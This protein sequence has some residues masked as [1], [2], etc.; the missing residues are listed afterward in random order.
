MD[1]PLPDEDN[2]RGR[3][4]S[5][6][7]RRIAAAPPPGAM[8]SVSVSL[9]ETS[10]RC[11]T[12]ASG[13]CCQCASG[14]SAYSSRLNDWLGGRKSNG[15]LKIGKVDL[16]ERRL[17]RGGSFLNLSLNVRSSTRVNYGPTMVIDLFGVRPSRTYR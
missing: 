11:T 5:Y 10:F 17:L 16:K 8:V 14:A 15:R 4:E 12:I 13:L 1:K 9:A 6:L 2:R 3:H 7:G